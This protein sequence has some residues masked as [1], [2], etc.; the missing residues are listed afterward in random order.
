MV[1]NSEWLSVIRVKICDKF[2]NVL[3]DTG[4]N[5]SAISARYARKMEYN[6]EPEEENTTTILYTANGQGIRSLGTVT[7]SLDLCG[8]IC[9]QKFEVL[10]DLTTNLIAG[11]D[12]M[13]NHNVMVDLAK[14]SAILNEQKRV[15]LIHKREYL[16][17]ARLNAH[18][19][20]QPHSTRN[21]T[22]YIGSRYRGDIF[23]L[24]LPEPI[25]GIRVRTTMIKSTR[26]V[27]IT[28]YNETE[29]PIWLQ[30]LGPIASCVR[31]TQE[32]RSQLNPLGPESEEE[33]KERIAKIH[34]TRRTISDLNLKINQE[35]YVKENIR[36]FK[37]VLQDNI[38][39]FALTNAELPG[40]TLMKAKFELKDPNSKPVRGHVFNYSQNA[41]LEIEK[42]VAQL[43]KDD[44]IERS[45]SPYSSSALLVKKSDNT[46][47]FCQDYRNINKILKPEF[48][49][50]STLAEIVER[51]GAQQPKI[52]SSI[53]LRSAYY[54]ILVEEGPSRDYCA[55]TC[56]LGTFAFK[57]MSFGIQSA[58][59]KFMMLMNMVIGSD[60]MLQKHVIPCL[61][62]LLLFTQTLEE[63]TEVLKRLMKALRD[64]GLRIHPGKCEFLQRS[65][66]YV[67]HIFSDK[68]VAANPTKLSAILD[69]PTPK[70]KRNLKGF[71]GMVSFYRGYH[72]DLSKKVAPLLHLLKKDQKF[73]WTAE[74]EQ[75]FQ[76][77]RQGLKE[78]PV[79]IYPDERPGA[80]R[81]IIQV[82]ASD[83]AI[84]GTFSQASRDGKEERL[85]A[86][87]GRSLRP[88]ERNWH[89]SDK[90]GGAL[91]IAL[92]RWKHLILGNPALEIRSDNMSVTFLERIKHATSPRL[93]RWS[94]TMSPLLA[95]ATWTHIPG[96]KNIVADTLSRQKYPPEDPLPGE[97]DLLYDDLSFG[98]LSDEVQED[99]T[100]KEEGILEETDNT[101]IW[102]E[103]EGYYLGTKD[104]FNYSEISTE[105]DKIHELLE[106]IYEDVEQEVEKSNGF[107]VNQDKEAREESETD[108]SANT[109]WIRYSQEEPQPKEKDDRDFVQVM[110]ES[111][112]QLT[113]NKI[114][115]RLSDSDTRTRIKENSMSQLETESGS[116]DNTKDE[117]CI[118]V[119]I[120]SGSNKDLIQLQRECPEL[121]PL[122][123]YLETGDLGESNAKVARKI[124]NQAEW[125]FLDE[126]GVLCATSPRLMS[127]KG[128]DE[129]DFKVIP[130]TLRQEMMSGFHQ[131]AH[132]GIGRLYELILKAGYKW[133]RLY[134]DVRNFVLS[135]QACSVAKR[136]VIASRAKLKPLAYPS[137]SFHTIQIDIIGPLSPSSS[138]HIAILSVVDRLTSWPWLFPL[139][140]CTS[141]VIAKKLFKVFADAGV[142]RVLISD[143]AQNLVSKT[144]QEMAGRLGIEH[145]QIA[146]Y[147]S[148]SNGLC[149][150]L[151]LTAM[152]SLRSLLVGGDPKQWN[153]KIPE[154]VWGLRSAV[155]PITKRSAYELTRGFQM[156]LPADL[157]LESK[158][159]NVP[160]A[161][162]TDLSEYAKRLEE[163]IKTIQKVHKEKLEEGQTE[164]KR[165]YDENIRKMHTYKK[166]DKVYLKDPV[167]VPNVS[168][169]LQA[170]YYPDVFEIIEVESEHNV[171]LRNIEKNE[172]LKNPVHV[173]RI[174]ARIDRESIGNQASEQT[175]NPEYTEAAQAE[176]EDLSET[177]PTRA[178][179]NLH[180]GTSLPTVQGDEE[181]RTRAVRKVTKN[182]VEQPETVSKTTYK[183]IRQKGF[184]DNRT[185]QVQWKRPD[186]KYQSTWDDCSNLTKEMIENWERVK[187]KCGR[188][189]KEFRR[190]RR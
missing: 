148:Q 144:I 84:A 5:K 131:F 130:V 184:G 174:K 55:F 129:Q 159:G 52:F 164:M 122:M 46:L 25:K 75:A 23:L 155:S 111:V 53:D 185:F 161:E 120:Y 7:L 186:G 81:Y 97:E 71:L 115:T 36:E 34:P 73:V 153:T 80:G 187:G 24:D 45:R 50:P 65:V 103:L 146:P 147:H 1:Y 170:V 183:I 82:D 28:L 66:K 13:R 43:L 149:E 169:K 15:P 19:M 16:G 168:K 142:P 32:N 61:D 10:K 180:W 26:P 38:D 68:G 165:R 134:G 182:T 189:L 49:N 40:C 136:G 106:D 91:M 133:E 58:P 89:S 125:H 157:K 99:G 20:M 145:V 126:E 67:G 12:F 140:S 86:C 22:V 123:E 88:N 188:T 143:R 162:E 107:Q 17:I 105:W 30:K 33:R 190:R 104:N 101:R 152:N 112:K 94:V 83:Y 179:D 44:F 79:L 56:H 177:E 178:A 154:V 6:I 109:I 62:D 64:A 87:Y 74:C 70:T 139:K 167:G 18:T 118:G 29:N 171:R 158:L 42:Q 95:N 119:E 9:Q 116:E 48:Y 31:A 11:C 51:V 2:T 63:H 41:K 78:L 98:V 100:G 113:S 92:L 77:I 124:L 132:C 173:D 121:G 160:I 166:G 90:E 4:A 96:S 57:R 138:G 3:L 172:I 21:V 59:A 135:C 181:P 108:E 76:E 85:I 150:R 127:R 128:K 117:E 35:N 14:G 47:R 176:E 39:L 151:H 175:K 114:R 72:A 156:R 110:Q 27:Q 93:A 69:F 60:K 163:Q 54:Q 8:T 141:D 137:K 102:K 37:K